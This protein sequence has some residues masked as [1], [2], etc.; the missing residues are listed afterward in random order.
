MQIALKEIPLHETLHFLGW[1]GT[2]LDQPLLDQ[3]KVVTQRALEAIEPR[4]VYR[5]ASL[6]DGRT[7]EG[8][9]FCV[10]G[11]DAAAMLQPCHEI[12]LFAATLGAQSERMLLKEQAKDGAQAVLLDAV[13]SAAIEALCD[14][15]EARL[16]RELT[17]GG[18][19][20]TDRFSPGY[21][22][23]PLS[24]SRMICEVLNT[25]RSIGLTVSASGIMIPRKSVTA[26]MGVSR[27]PVSLRPR[28]CAGCSMRETC[29]MRRNGG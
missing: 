8:T 28:G 16:R 5:R 2:P 12:I 22:D 18:L 27:T 19:Y 14:R 26:V 13:F 3:I 7:A 15:A 29:P 1:R 11:A 21:G 9:A 10:E 4:V 23:M 6:T 20:L 24:Q 17:E 25:N